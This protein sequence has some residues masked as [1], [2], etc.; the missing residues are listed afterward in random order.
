MK[1]L[2]LL[3][4]LPVLGGCSQFGIL[5][6]MGPLP[7]SINECSGMVPAGQGAVWVL[8][9]GGNAA[10][11]RK[12]DPQG[13]LLTSLE[14]ENAENEDW[15]ALT[16]DDQGYLYI[17]DFGNN[18][19][20]R[21][22]LVI[23]RVPDPDRGVAQ[24]LEAEAIAFR[25]PDQDRFPPKRAGMKFDAEAFFHHGDSLYLITKNRAVPFDGTATVYRIPD[26]PGEYRA[27]IVARLKLCGDARTCQVTDAALS[28][29]GDRLV[30]L[31]YGKLFVYEAFSPSR[32]GDQQGRVI[33]LR[34]NTQ[35]EAVCFAA[36][37]LLYL[38]DERSLRRGGNLY[39]LPLP[40]P[41]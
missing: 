22:D 2:L 21:K 7:R 3:L 9:D 13:Q 35:L 12:L 10:K 15:E 8:E 11:L 19:N 29:K 37:T 38:A 23:Y 40:R 14:V 39:R 16:A 20:E 41:E 24:T 30:L 6:R 27:E 32:L 25:Y 17:G 31:S 18:T 36:D 28:P 33:E 5:E 26:Q 34:T 1:R 4:C